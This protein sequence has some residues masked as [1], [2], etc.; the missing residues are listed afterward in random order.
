MTDDHVAVAQANRLFYAAV[1]AA[2][3]EKMSACWL[4][5]NWVKCTHPGWEVL[6]GWNDVKASWQECN[7]QTTPNFSAVAYYF[8]RDLQK[9]RNIPV[10]LIHTSWGGSPAEVWMSE[11]VLSS[12][13]GYKR[14][15]LDKYTTDV[16]AHQA[17]L[18][19]LR[20]NRTTIC[21][22]HRLST[23][24]NAHRILCMENG[25]IVETG[26]HDQLLAR[27]GVYS[28]LYNLQFNY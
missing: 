8:G 1:Q 12:N 11:K 24:L 10:G 23:I 5:E 2:D 14:N 21:I 6:C 28:R 16:K 7:P 17:A 25:R 3:I 15:I 4:H 19:K 20:Q 18:E 26:T 13:P 27:K 22:A 9:A